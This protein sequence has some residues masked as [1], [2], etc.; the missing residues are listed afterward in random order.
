MTFAVMLNADRNHIHKKPKTQSHILRISYAR[1][2][3]YYKTYPPLS[4]NKRKSRKQGTYFGKCIIHYPTQAPCYCTNQ[5]DLKGTRRIV[6]F[7]FRVQKTSRL[8]RPARA[9]VVSSFPGRRGSGRLIFRRLTLTLRACHFVIIDFPFLRFGWCVPSRVPRFTRTKLGETWVKGS[10]S[11]I[12]C[13]ALGPR[14][15]I[16]YQV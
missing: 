15:G 13:F 10:R 9:R 5:I 2:H 3:T 6:S 7:V 12:L 8:K 1:H 11:I 16:F 14:T 4:F